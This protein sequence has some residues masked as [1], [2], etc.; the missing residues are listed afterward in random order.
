MPTPEHIHNSLFAIANKWQE[1][2]IFWHL[3]FAV[4][5]VGL[6][7]GVRPS[8]R[9][10]G[11]LLAL[12]F[13]SVSALAWISGN[14]FSGTTFA[15]SGAALII[16][17][18]RL[19]AGNV[20]LPSWWVVL[21]GLLMFAFGWVYPHFLDTASIVPYLYSAPIGL[22]P[23]PTLSIVIGLALVLGGLGSRAWSTVLGAMGIFYGLFG[24]IRLS[25]ALD[26]VLFLG[27]VMILIAVFSQDFRISGGYDT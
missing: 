12:P 21:T 20:R 15:F 4:L 17:A 19:P 7:K 1:I 24:P 14:P 27:A 22:I 23:C 9:V 11:I 8:K 26:W 10:A 18:I 13:L 2:A 5:A 6:L 16:I 3:Y 25:I